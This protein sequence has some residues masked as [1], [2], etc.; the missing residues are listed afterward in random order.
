MR[1]IANDRE[2]AIMTY[3][4]PQRRRFDEAPVDRGPP[5][6]SGMSWGLPL[7]IA[8]AFVVIAVIFFNLSHERTTTA[9]NNSAPAATTHSTNSAPNAPRGPD[10]ANNAPTQNTGNTA[11]PPAKQ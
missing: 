4:D 9:S 5:P 7:G 8:A 1:Y 10:A 2:G 11:Q 3:Q 6:D